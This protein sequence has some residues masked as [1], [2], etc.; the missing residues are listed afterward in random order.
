MKLRACLVLLLVPLVLAGCGGLD[1]GADEPSVDRAA[2]RPVPAN[3]GMEARAVGVLRAD[4]VTGCL[5]IETP[6]APGEMPLLLQG[7]S[8]RVDVDAS[9]AAVL[10][11]DTVVAKVG[12][13]IDVGGGNADPAEAGVEGCPVMGTIFLGYFYER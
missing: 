10:D 6:D 12:E 9:P 13:Q 11:G 5:W 4:P 7:D 8:Y 1:V 3:G 2:V